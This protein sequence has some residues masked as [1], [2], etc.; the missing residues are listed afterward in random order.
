MRA[1]V[2][3][4]LS[5]AEIRFFNSAR[6]LEDWMVANGEDV[7]LVSLDCDLDQSPAGEDVGSGE[8]VTAFLA[9]TLP[10]MP[11]LI[12]SSNTMRAP[13][14]H[15]DLTSRGCRRVLLCP[16]RD[17]NQWVADVQRALAALP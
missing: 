9:A 5:D 6:R 12:H 2:S 10:M 11:I 4:L 1:A 17:G 3:S 8:D 16:F 13:A 14:M 7:A 15:L